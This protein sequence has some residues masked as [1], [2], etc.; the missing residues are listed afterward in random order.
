MPTTGN[1]SLLTGIVLKMLINKEKNPG[2]FFPENSS[3][4]GKG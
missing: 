3:I 4:P 2:H 1:L